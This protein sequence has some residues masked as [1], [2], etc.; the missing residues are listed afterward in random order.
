MKANEDFKT[1]YDTSLLPVLQEMEKDRKRLMGKMRPFLILLIVLLI[2]CIVSVAMALRMN[3][4]SI[5]NQDYA[6]TEYQLIQLST[7]IGAGAWACLILLGGIYWLTYRFYFSKRIADLKIRFKQ[8]VVTQMIKSVDETLLYEPHHGIA[9]HDYHQ[10]QLIL[11]SI[12]SYACE[13]MISGKLGSTAIRFSEVHTQQKKESSN[14]N[15]GTSTTWRTIFKGIFF[16]ADFNKKFSGRTTVVPDLA[17]NLLGSFGTMFQKMEKSRGQLVKMED[18]EFEKE[19][20]VYS[21]DPVEAHYLLSPALMK[22]VMEFRRKSGKISFSFV[23]SSVFI[24]IPI[25]ASLNLFEPKIYSS[26]IDYKRIEEY[27]RYLVLLTGIVEDLNLNNRIWT[28]I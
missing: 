2:P 4:Q 15:G 12:D 6:S 20:A 5:Q 10:S 18:V 21:S 17:E 25:R 28:K 22:R 23:D 14:S 27:N 1:F 26:L 16:V 11:T 13:D 3:G 24:A 7:V 9:Q 8:N 19:F